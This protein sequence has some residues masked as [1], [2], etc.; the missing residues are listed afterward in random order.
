MKPRSL[1]IKN[2]VDVAIMTF[3]RPFRAGDKL[4]TDDV[5][6][7]V[8][9]MVTKYIRDETITRYLRMLR[10][11]GKINYEHIGEKRYRVIEIIPMDAPHSR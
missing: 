10:K 7:Y 3:L 11:A 4:M 9:K 5:I 8:R 6:S 1:P 2:K